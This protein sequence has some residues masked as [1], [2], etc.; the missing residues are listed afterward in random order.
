MIVLFRWLA[1]LPLTWLQACGAVLGWLVW[2]GSPTYRRQFHRQV[3]GSGVDPRRA[4]AAIAATGRMVAELP[5]VWARP[6]EDTLSWRVTWDGQHHVQAAL[7]AGRGVIIM[8]PHIG[9]WEVGAQ[10]LAEAFAG[11]DGAWVVLY[12]PP[13]HAGLR[14]LV[15]RS[16]ERSQVQG[17][18]TTLAGV[19]AIVRA[20]RRGAGTAILPDQVPPLGQGVWAPFWGREA[21]T[22]T[23]L[24]RLVQQTGA[25]VLLTWCERLP[26]GRFMMHV[27]PWSDPTWNDPEASPVQW[28][29][30]MNQA[31]ESLVRAHPEQYLW[32]YNRYKQPR[33]GD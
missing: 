6:H 7:A 10:A 27:Q 32:G 16:R 20:L 30:A 21:Y 12:R 15:E 13:R 29:S 33:E 19:R 24:P 23:L 26:A 17:V 1:R 3:A 8:S 31:I 9:S 11:Q 25:A 4:R 28:A 18:P 22:M 14:T 2:W 5:W